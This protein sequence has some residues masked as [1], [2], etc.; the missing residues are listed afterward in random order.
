MSEGGRFLEKAD[1]GEARRD[2]VPALSEEGL[3]A[4]K[5]AGFVELHEKSQAGL[6]RS[7]SL[8]EIVAVERIGLFQPQGVAGPESAGHGPGGEKPVKPLADALDRGEQ[9]E[10]VLAGVAGAAEDQSLLPPAD[11][12]V[13]RQGEVRSHEGPERGTPGPLHGEGPELGTAVEE[14]HVLRGM[15]EQPLAVLIDARRVDDEEKAILPG[16]IEDEIVDD[17]SRFVEQQGVLSLPHPERG[18]LVGEKSLEPRGGTRARDFEFTHVR[19]VEDTHTGPHREMFGHNSLI[20]DRHL[21]TREGDETCAVGQVSVMEG[22][23]VHGGSFD[24]AP[25]KST[26]RRAPPSRKWTPGDR[27]A[28]EI[29]AIPRTFPAMIR[30]TGNRL[31]D[32][33]ERRLGRLA[34]PRILHWVAG[35][36]VLSFGLSLFSPDYLEY[37]VYDRKAILQGEVWRALS[38]VAFPASLNLFFF[39]CTTLLTL[40][41]S[42]SLEGEW[43]SFRVN[44][45]VLS[46][47]LMLTFA[48]FLPAIGGGSVYFGLI[49]FSSVFLAFATVYPDQILNLFGIIP[50][51]AKWLGMADALILLS[52]ILSAPSPFWFT[53]LVTAGLLPYLLTFVPGFADS[54]RRESV[55]RVR[56]HRF[57]AEAAEGDSFHRCESCGVTELTDPAREFRVASDGHEYCDTCRKP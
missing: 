35:F 50:I 25:A 34:L 44:L 12:V 56:R 49:F 52:L 14:N 38:W 4:E 40:F 10:P 48:G 17:P 51:K 46:T 19:D 36:Q 55:A 15:G 31:I 8:V 7:A 16:T 6:E 54:F 42:N 5:T 53:L 30:E 13:R 3:P 32:Q 41:I 22:R 23:A 1:G 39:L 20:L 57:E 26:D 11:S 9:L 24:P 47:I 29:P 43:G 37:V 45:Y 18:D 21:P 27:F 2:P 33:L 28:F